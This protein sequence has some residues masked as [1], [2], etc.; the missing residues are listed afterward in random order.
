M[1][2][3]KARGKTTIRAR[4]IRASGKVEDLGVLAGGTWWQRL[5]RL[6]ARLVGLNRKGG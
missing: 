4:V 6:A 3:S 5:K 2:L 1:A